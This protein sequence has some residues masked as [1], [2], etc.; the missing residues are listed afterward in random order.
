LGEDDAEQLEDTAEAATASGALDDETAVYDKRD[1]ERTA[2]KARDLDVLSKRPDDPGY[3]PP[4]GAWDTAAEEAQDAWDDFANGTKDDLDR[5]E[6]A[7]PSALWAAA[8][9]AVE[10]MAVVDEVADVDPATLKAE[11]DAA[12]VAYAKA[13]DDEAAARW[14]MERAGTEAARRREA[15][16]AL[17]ASAPDR[18]ASL[19]RGD[20]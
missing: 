16:D 7:V 14:A 10:A 12:E 17:A 19:V 15:I 8:L 18:M 3:T 4:A 6:V 20:I 11:L 9:A 13:L 1:A 2:W 5:W